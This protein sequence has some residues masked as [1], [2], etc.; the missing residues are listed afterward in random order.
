MPMDISVSPLNYADPRQAEA[1]ILLMEAY[2]KDPM[3]G[4]QGLSEQVKAN[5]AVELAERPH[6]FGVMAYVDG[7]PAGLINCFEAFSTFK[8]KTLVNIHDVV[9]LPKYRSLGISRL[10]LEKVQD[11]ARS[12]GCCKLTLEVLEG[13]QRAQAIY[14]KFGFC[15]YELDPKAGRALFWEKSLQGQAP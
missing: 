14:Q 10:M 2:A 5:L 1:L 6:A 13:N 8:C 12:K 7:Q 11:I 3:G 9:V 15:A 4:G